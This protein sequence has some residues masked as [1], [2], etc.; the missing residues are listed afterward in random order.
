MQI[1][2]GSG[3]Q[4]ST[5]GKQ[6]LDAALGSRI[7]VEEFVRQKVLAWIIDIRQLAE[8]VL[9]QSQAAYVPYIHQLLSRWS[10][11]L[12]TIPDIQDLENF[13]HQIIIPAVPGHPQCSK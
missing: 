6:Y 11:L 10:S 12:C 8:A 1:F 4:I 2:A 5:K 7:L 9:I 13:I 3:L